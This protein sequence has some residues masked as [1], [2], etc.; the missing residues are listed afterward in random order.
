MP[1]SRIRRDDRDG[2]MFAPSAEGSL[3]VLAA[4]QRPDCDG[5][6]AFREDGPPLDLAYGPPDRG[7]KA[8]GVTGS[9]ADRHFRPRETRETHR[10]KNLTSKQCNGTLTEIDISSPERR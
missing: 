9:A 5:R 6:I 8:G 10:A 1:G 3:E 2:F 4:P 7:V